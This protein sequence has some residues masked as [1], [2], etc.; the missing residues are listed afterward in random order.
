MHIS[1]SPSNNFFSRFFLLFLAAFSI[2][3]TGCSAPSGES[4]NIL[5]KQAES[6]GKPA[7]SNESGKSLEKIETFRGLLA[8]Q[9]NGLVLTLCGGQIALPVRDE[10]KGRL[11]A[12]MKLFS[13]DSKG[14]IFTEILGTSAP[15]SVGLTAWELLHASAVGES[16][17]CRERFG[18]FSFKAMGNEPGWTMRVTPGTLS[19]TTMD[20]PEPRRFTGVSTTRSGDDA[21]F[22]GDNVSLTLTRGVCMDTMSGEQFGWQAEAVVDGAAYKGCAVKGD[23]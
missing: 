19:L 21:V 22:T 16:W 2:L 11:Q 4:N 12:A 17:G 23:L 10:T 8:A 3:S 14:P 20:S 5:S 18:E 15:S 9:D 13:P 7:Y 1:K 6:A